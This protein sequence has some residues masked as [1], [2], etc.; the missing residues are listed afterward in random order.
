MADPGA[1]CPPHG[2]VARLGKLE[3]AVEPRIPTDIQAAPGERDQRP[4]ARRPGRRVGLP[5]RRL[6]DAWRDGWT[7]AE[8]LGVDAVRRD[9]PTREA[10]GQIVQEFGRPAYVEVA[11]ARYA[12]LLERAHVQTPRSIEFS[13]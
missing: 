4:R 9:P 10:K 12:D 5:S 6:G 7:R 13:I 8:N 11:I 2:Y 1:A 3:N